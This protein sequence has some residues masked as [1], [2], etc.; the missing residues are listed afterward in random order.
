MKKKIIEKLKQS[1]RKSKRTSIIKLFLWIANVKLAGFNYIYWTLY[2]NGKNYME[3]SY[4]MQ[5]PAKMA[6]LKMLNTLDVSVAFLPEEWYN[7]R[8]VKIGKMLK[9]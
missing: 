4:F 6:T 9:L 5:A 8:S 1:L 3:M 7:S 2:R